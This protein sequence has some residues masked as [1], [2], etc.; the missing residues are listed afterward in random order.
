MSWFYLCVKERGGEHQ[1][2][3]LGAHRPLLSCRFN[4]CTEHKASLQRKR[5]RIL[6]E[7]TFKLKRGL[8]TER[9]ARKSRT[10]REIRLCPRKGVAI[11]AEH[12][13]RLNNGDTFTNDGRNRHCFP[14]LFCS[15]THLITKWKKKPGWF[16][17]R[18]AKQDFFKVFFYSSLRSIELLWNISHIS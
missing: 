13:C 2:W 6:Q 10:Q 17:S 4:T 1:A 5:F 16:C 15:P 8:A 9:D 12:I 14:F 18:K 11:V 3:G 7:S